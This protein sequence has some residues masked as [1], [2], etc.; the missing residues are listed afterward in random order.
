MTK[1]R[2]SL[3]TA[4]TI[5]LLAGYE[6]FLS[7]DEPRPANPASEEQGHPSILLAAVTSQDGAATA[8]SRRSRRRPTSYKVV[9][10]KNGGTISGVVKYQGEIP[11]PKKPQIV[12]DHETCGHHPSEVPLINVDKDGRVA[13]AVVFLAD[14]A[15]GK[16]FP[17][18]GAPPIIDQKACQF[19]PHVQVVRARQPVEIVNS[20]PVAH[21]INASQ[22]IYTLFNILQPQQNMRATQ[23]FDRPGLVNLRCNVHDWMQA[24]VYVVVHPYVVITAEDGT[25]K[26]DDVPAGKYE[27][28]VW[29]EYLDEQTFDVEVKPGETS[30]LSLTLKP[31]AAGASD[32]KAS[33]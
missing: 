3:F 2:L 4:L 26:F 27:L 13:E 24:Y 17:K 28:A 25:F 9:E 5:C 10:V 18:S 7:A 6:S 15:E 11:P 16:D 1:P 21:N 8:S 19:H 32:T 22:R 31:K 33:H 12:K 23:Q 14:I 20:D 29:Q 30:T